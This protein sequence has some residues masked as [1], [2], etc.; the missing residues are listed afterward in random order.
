MQEYRITYRPEVPAMDRALVIAHKV[1]GWRADYAFFGH[2]H[3]RNM[4]TSLV[5]RELVRA[6]SWERYVPDPD[7]DRDMQDDVSGE[8]VY[9]VVYTTGTGDSRVSG[10]EGPYTREEAETRGNVLGAQG[11]LWKVEHV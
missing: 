7:P 5:P 8:R 9:N 6:V 4:V 10:S 11:Y 1:E 3:D 2:P